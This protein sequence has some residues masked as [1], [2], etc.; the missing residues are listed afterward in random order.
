MSN[1]EYRMMRYR[2][3]LIGVLL[4]STIMGLRGQALAD[5]IY[6][7]YIS[8]DMQS[9]VEVMDEMKADYKLTGNIE[10]LKEITICQYGY[11]AICVARGDKK[12]GREEL[13]E[14][15]CNVEVLLRHDSEWAVIHALKGAFYAFKIGFDPYKF[16]AYGRRAREENSLAI[17]LSPEDPYV[18]ME[19]G[20][21]ELYW[22][23]LQS[24][25][26]ASAVDA[27]L[28]STQFYERNGELTRQNW[29]YLNTM[30]SLAAAYCKEEEYARAD[31]IYKKILRIEPN[32][33]WIRDRDYPKFRAKYM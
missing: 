22:P 11:I 1:K 21:I 2:V 15:E 8:N 29:L 5:R 9:W 13:R 10:M 17:D 27:Y 4:S 26:R 23:D 7:A 12:D 28:K 19:K 31:E 18:W 6:K 33:V 20:N 3:L 14:A 16:V 30:V 24:K 25:G 32:I